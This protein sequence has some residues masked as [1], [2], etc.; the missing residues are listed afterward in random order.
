MKFIVP[1]AYLQKQLTSISG[2]IANNPTIPILENFLFEAS[3]GKLMATASDSQISM[4]VGL[5]VDMQEEGKI[6]VPSK[7]LIETLRNLPEQPITF[8]M[9]EESYN[10][11]ISSNNGQYKLVGENATDFPKLRQRLKTK[12]KSIFFPL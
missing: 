5:E 6:A 2:V 9:D 7:I 12:A 4:T 8:S 10:I 3:D 1:S 11:E